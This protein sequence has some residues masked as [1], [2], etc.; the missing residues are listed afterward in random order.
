M[1]PFFKEMPSNRGHQFINGAVSLNPIAIAFCGMFGYL[2]KQLDRFRFIT[3]FARIIDRNDRFD[4]DGN[5]KPSALHQ[6]DPLET[7]SFDSHNLI[8]SKK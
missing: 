5:D 1:N 8:Q 6:P 3:R 4:L 7:F 2:A